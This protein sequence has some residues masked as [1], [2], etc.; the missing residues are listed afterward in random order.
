[1]RPASSAAWAVSSSLALRPKYVA[2]AACTPVEGRERYVLAVPADGCRDG[3]DDESSPGAGVDEQRGHD[4][5][6]AG[7][8]GQPATRAPPDE[9]AR[10]S[11]RASADGATC[12]GGAGRDRSP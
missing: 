12:S 8:D 10:G 3:C 2:G 6:R 1:M 11:K 4:E 7:G 9:P 5:R